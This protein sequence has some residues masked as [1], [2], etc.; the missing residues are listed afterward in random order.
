MHC[1]CC[2]PE[3]PAGSSSEDLIRKV[4]QIVRGE[5]LEIPRLHLT[6]SQVQ[7]LWGLDADVCDRVLEALLEAGFLTRTSDGAYVRSNGA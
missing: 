5:Y 2:Q 6:H 1:E 4:T 7:H 3:R